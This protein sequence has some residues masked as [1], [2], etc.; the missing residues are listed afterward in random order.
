MS[1][2]T[3]VAVIGG[4]GNV[5]PSIV[6][7]LLHAGFEVTV[8]SRSESAQ[9]SLP[10]AVEVKQ[11]NY[12]DPSSVTTALRGQHA[13]VSNVG[14]MA[15]ADQYK[16]VDSAIEAGVPWFLPSEFGVDK[17]NPN[18]ISLPVFAAK[19]TT[20]RYL[21]QKAAEGKISY[22]IVS[23]GSFLDWGIE[24]GMIINLKP[25]ATVELYDGGDVPTSTTLLLDVGKAVAGVLKVP[26]QAKN[27]SILVSS[28][29][30]TQNQ[31]LKIA[32][33]LRPDWIPKTKVVNTDD[34]LRNSMEVLTSGKGDM[35]GAMMGQIQ[36]SMFDPAYGAEFPV[37]DNEL[38]GIKR[39]TP[40]EL[41]NV[42]AQYI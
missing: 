26:E 33:K 29:T 34:L 40:E 28:A 31:L 11:V 7:G 32:E 18:A 8:L 42:V 37:L 22:I 6:N 19:A 21:E 5:G 38:V 17:S 15:L 41:E 13:V 20:E 39:L 2:I 35:V 10:A 36:K 12:A 23:T 27:K 16:L 25:D 1:S 24:H 14:F 3:K 4:T 9:S 30:V